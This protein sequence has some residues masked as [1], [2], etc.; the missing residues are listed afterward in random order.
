MLQISLEGVM[1]DVKWNQM[2]VFDLVEYNM[3]GVYDLIIGK[4]KV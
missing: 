4:F 1:F 3:G 2:I